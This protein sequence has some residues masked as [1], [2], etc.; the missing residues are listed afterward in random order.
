MLHGSTK[1]AVPGGR[2]SVSEHKDKVAMS[3]D[4]FVKATTVKTAKGLP[5]GPVTA[6]SYISFGAPLC[7][8]RLSVLEISRCLVLTGPAAEANFETLQLQ[9]FRSPDCSG[10]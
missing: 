9:N 2:P 6:F 1:V 7:G 8:D 5:A 4:Y 3:L 10:L